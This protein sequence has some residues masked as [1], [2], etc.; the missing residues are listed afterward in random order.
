MKLCQ[1]SSIVLLSFLMSFAI[2]RIAFACISD[3]DCQ[4]GHY[5][6]FNICTSGLPDSNCKTDKDCKK[7]E[8][9]TRSHGR[10]V[11]YHRRDN[12]HPY[13]PRNRFGSCNVGRVC[14][15]YL[16]VEI[17]KESSSQ[18]QSFAEGIN[19]EQNTSDAATIRESNSPEIR[20]FE[21]SAAEWSRAKSPKPAVIS[22][23]QTSTVGCSLGNT[24]STLFH[25]YSIFLFGFLYCLRA[26]T[27]SD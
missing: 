22:T 16:C 8:S 5:C 13:N 27:S 2:P 11:C 26:A 1:Y 12:C 25:L 18:E 15:E 6:V 23:P 24:R 3:S 4:T 7:W 19:K 17:V 21:S 20:N 14:K 10:L 9:C